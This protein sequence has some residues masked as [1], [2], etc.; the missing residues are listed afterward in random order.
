MTEISIAVEGVGNASVVAERIDDWRRRFAP[1]G[2]TTYERLWLTSEDGKTRSRKPS[3]SVWADALAGLA[4]GRITSVEWEPSRY[5]SQFPID[6]TFG[7]SEAPT[8]GRVAFN[9]V[10]ASAPRHE[11]DRQADVLEWGTETLTALESGLGWADSVA[12]M[13]NRSGRA[14]VD[15][16]GA[17]GDAWWAMW[18]DGPALEQLGGHEAVV[19][20]WPGCRAEEL[21]A[22]GRDLVLTMIGDRPDLVEHSEYLRAFRFLRPV[23][24]ESLE[25]RVDPALLT[26]LQLPAP[27]VWPGDSPDHVRAGPT[28][29]E[30]RRAPMP[31]ADNELDATF[32]A[33][34]DDEQGELRGPL[35]V[36]HPERGVL[37]E[38]S[39]WMGESQARALARQRRWRYSRDV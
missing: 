3:E 4:S 32:K 39:E 34:E 25:P 22:A 27:G 1:A 13:L 35:I 15:E 6:V 37:W 26:E 21:P 38:S 14:G 29:E 17:F 5:E 9:G 20:S 8:V 28:D 7:S 24:M 19:S 31:P 16:R 23:L 18:I 10:V 12:E 33:E 30:L 11:C 2:S 36:S